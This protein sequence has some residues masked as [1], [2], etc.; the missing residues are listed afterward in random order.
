VISSFQ[1]GSTRFEFRAYLGA[2]LTSALAQTAIATVVG[3]QVWKLT[4]DPLSLGWLGLVEAIP[5]ISLSLFG[6]HLADRRDRRTIVLAATG[7]LTLSALLLALVAVQTPSLGV[8]A[9]YG[10]VFLA[11]LAGGFLFPAMT[12]FEAQVIPLEY[13]A[14]GNSWSSGVMLT[15]MVAGPAVGGIAVAIVGVAGT[16]VFLAALLAI[17]AVGIALIRPK[18]IPPVVE[19]ETMRRSIAQGVR[20]VFSDQRL[21]GSMALDLFAVLFGGVE[22]LLPIFA[23]QILLVGPVGLGVLR[24]APSVGALLVTFATTRL[25]PTRRAGPLLIS[26]VAGFGV[27]I[28]VFAVSTSFWLSVLALFFSGIADGMSMIIR[29]LILRVLSPEEMRGRIGSVSSIFIGA[30]NEIGAFE[31]G[32]TAS[33]FGVVPSVVLGAVVTLGVAGTVAIV[34]PQLRTLDLRTRLMPPGVVPSTDPDALAAFE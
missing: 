16:Y 24:T 34:A 23:D 15:G 28:L 25:P 10:P 19:Q 18:P 2:R 3:Y 13:A 26:C 29:R 27:S 12:A 1:R 14:K 22:A 6:G 8:L 30:S 11:G 33:I 7:V 5:N 9:I 21:V 17:A 4:G 20:F 31:S 32:I